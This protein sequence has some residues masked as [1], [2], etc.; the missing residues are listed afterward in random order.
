[1]TNSSSGMSKS[2]VHAMLEIIKQLEVSLD[3]VYGNLLRIIDNH[4]ECIKDVSWE[5]AMSSVGESLLQATDKIMIAKGHTSSIVE[6]ID[7]AEE[8]EEG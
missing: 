8:E 4:S 6:R 7:D 5:Y 2:D 3:D 1:M